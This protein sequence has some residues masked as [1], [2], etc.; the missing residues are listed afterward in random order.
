MCTFSVWDL[1]RIRSLEFLRNPITNR[2]EVFEVQWKKDFD[3]THNAFLYYAI[4]IL[5]D[6]SFIPFTLYFPTKGNWEFVGIFLRLF[7]YNWNSSFQGNADETGAQ[8]LLLKGASGCGTRANLE[9]ANVLTCIP[10][11]NLIMKEQRMV[12]EAREISSLFFFEVI[13]SLRML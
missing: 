7:S 5:F 2:H 3:L 12:G 9:K 11:L 6:I 4:N 8:R 1:R 10:L 13:G